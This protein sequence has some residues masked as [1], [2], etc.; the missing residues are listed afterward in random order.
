MANGTDAP[1]PSSL[2]EEIEAALSEF[3]AG[4][5]AARPDHVIVAAARKISLAAVRYTR[6]PEISVDVD[7]ELSFDLRLADGRLLLAEL[8]VNGRAHVGIHDE[9]DRLAEHHTADYRFLSSMIKPWEMPFPP[10]E[11]VCRF[12]QDGEGSKREGRPR[13]ELS[14]R[15]GFPSGILIVCGRMARAWKIFSRRSLWDLAPAGLGGIARNHRL[16]HAGIVPTLPGHSGG[17]YG[18]ELQRCG[19]AFGREGDRQH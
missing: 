3:A 2:P 4:G 9:N 18:V 10:E 14:S 17:R 5:E 8:G 13:Q 19:G 12:V 11:T 16:T 7:G 1:A 6:E 15:Q